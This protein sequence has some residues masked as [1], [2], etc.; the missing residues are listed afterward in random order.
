MNA[1]W[2]LCE[3]SEQL[4]TFLEVRC[5][6][7]ADPEVAPAALPLG[8]LPYHSLASMLNKQL[9]G[10]A[11]VPREPVTPRKVPARTA[12]PSPAALAQRVHRAGL[13]AARNA[14]A[15]ARIAARANNPPANP[16]APRP[17][18]PPIP[19]PPPGPHFTKRRRRNPDGDA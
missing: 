13:T 14:R 6:D 7:T 2:S 3:R 15:Q 12:N 9:E 17:P 11:A 16:P 4:S 5:H 8:A 10:T 18:Q 1:W 19:G